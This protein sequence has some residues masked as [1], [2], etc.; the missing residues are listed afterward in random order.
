MESVVVATGSSNVTMPVSL[1]LLLLLVVAVV[2]DA[3]V[4]LQHLGVVA[5]LLC[6]HTLLEAMATIDF[7]LVTTTAR[8]RLK[9]VVGYNCW[10]LSACLTYSRNW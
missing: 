10:L 2:V 7:A 8:G 9:N 5:S 3:V 4:M 6:I 1:L